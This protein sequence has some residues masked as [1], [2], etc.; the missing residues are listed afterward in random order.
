MS[1]GKGASGHEAMC[2]TFSFGSFAMKSWI[3]SA[4]ASWAVG[5]LSIYNPFPIHAPFLPLKGGDGDIRKIQKQLF[6]VLTASDHFDDVK[7]IQS[8]TFEHRYMTRGILELQAFERGIVSS[9]A[10]K[11]HA[12]YK[13]V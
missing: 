7:E 1:S 5:D 10:G 11:V 13:I 6:E 2:K 3:L 9:Q 4:N 12:L 8:R